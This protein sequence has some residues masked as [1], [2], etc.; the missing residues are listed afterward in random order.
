M[1]KKPEDLPEVTELNESEVDEMIRAVEKSS[2]DPSVK[3]III[4]CVELA[5]WLPGLL[6]RK[7]ISLNRLR[8]MLF[9]KGY[10][11]K[12]K[13]KTGSHPGNEKPSR[14]D[15]LCSHLVSSTGGGS[16]VPPDEKNSRT[17]E[18]GDESTAA[19]GE[20]E[21]SSLEQ[22]NQNTADNTSQ[23]MA[24][25]AEKKPGHGRMPSAVYA[26]VEEKIYMVLDGLQKGDVCPERCGGR[27]STYGSGTVIRVKGQNLAKVLHYVVE[28]L[29]CSLCGLIVTASLPADVGDEKYDNSFKALMAIQKY[30]VAVPF[31]RQE[32]FQAL[33]GFPLPNSTQWELVEK[34]AQ[35]CYA[36][37]NALKVLTANGKLIYHDDTP[38]KILEHI[39]MI[40]AKS[41]ER[42][43]MFTTCII[44]EYEGHQISLFFNG[45]KY[46]GENVDDLLALRD[47]DKGPILQ[48]CDG[49]NQQNSTKKAKTIMCNCMSHGFR[50]FEELQDYYP[51]ECRTIMHYIGKFFGLDK[52][53]TDMTDEARLMHHQTYSQPVAD[54][55]W[56]YMLLRFRIF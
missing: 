6:L 12:Q 26:T 20:K 31:N 32:Y 49:L 15:D 53:T 41:P 43:G 24:Q 55:L 29:R 21:P 27:L 54:A 34:V 52:T 9:G 47:A 22:S 37:F 51:E 38:L 40:K 17:Q 23:A 5:L 42:V 3:R 10:K 14:D 35:R 4:K 11:N 8:R 56:R 18:D 7:N 30:Y 19:T 13:S 28:K 2:L 50:K 16:D 39:K 48:M 44:G 33:L 45:V 36:P 25:A 1:S 46:S